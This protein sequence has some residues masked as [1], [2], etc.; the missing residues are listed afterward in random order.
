[1]LSDIIN[2]AQMPVYVVS[3]AIF[4]F[5]TYRAFTIGRVLVSG[6]YR[7]RAFWTG[8]TMITLILFT[9]ASDLP[10]SNP[11]STLSFLAIGLV[12][13]AFVDSSIRVAQEMDFF[14]RSPL[15]WQ[16]L[17]KPTLR[18][19]VRSFRRRGPSLLPRILE[20]RR[21]RPGGGS[22][23]RRDHIGVFILGGGSGRRSPEDSRE[24]D[25]EVR[26]DARA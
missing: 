10:S 8:G 16:R 6:A 17:R 7:N 13:L 24:V 26:Q 23:V 14:H 3:V 18:L 2:A 15:G 1:M 5:A 11:L 19:L 12:L 4:L 9:L 20:R 21:L 22:L 25:E